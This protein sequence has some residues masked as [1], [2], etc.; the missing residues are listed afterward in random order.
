MTATSALTCGLFTDLGQ[1]EIDELEAA[2]Q[3]RPQARAAQRRLAADFTALLHGRGRSGG[4]SPHPRHCSAEAPWKSC[5]TG[6]AGGGRRRD[7]RVGGLPRPGRS[8]ARGDRGVGRGPGLC[9]SRSDA[10]RAIEQGGVYVNNAKVTDDDRQL[11]PQ[12][13]LGGSIALLRRGKR[14]LAAVRV[15]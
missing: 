3:E 13:L 5:P 14:A 1:P 7:P 2:V 12:D 11:T 4:S 15:A 10:R 9:S 8:R 6:D